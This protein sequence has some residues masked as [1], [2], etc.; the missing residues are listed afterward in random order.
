MENETESKMLSFGVHLVS[1]ARSLRESPG[2]NWLRQEA[3]AD[4][5]GVK[6]QIPDADTDRSDRPDPPA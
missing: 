5:R 4:L 2:Q 6:G 3:E 1:I